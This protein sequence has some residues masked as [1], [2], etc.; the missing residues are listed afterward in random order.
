MDR[1]KATVSNNCD[2][3]PSD[4]EAILESLAALRAC[5]AEMERVLVTRGIAACMRLN[6]K[7][8]ER[9]AALEAALR[10]IQEQRGC[11][12]DDGQCP[13]YARCTYCIAAAALTPQPATVAP[14]EC[15]CAGDPDLDALYREGETVAKSATFQPLEDRVAEWVRTR[16]G[17]DHMNSRERSMRLLEEA[18]ELAQAEGISWGLAAKQVAHVYDREPG[19]PSQEA[20]GVAICLLG[21]CAS[22]SHTFEDLATKE[23]ARIEAKPLDQIRGSLARKADA[24]LVT[25]PTPGP[26]APRQ[27]PRYCEPCGRP[28]TKFDANGTALCDSCHADIERQR[29]T[30]AE[31]GGK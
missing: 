27:S 26:A 11:D 23:L 25:M 3:R 2:M 29:K 5:I 19:E 28:A 6:A 22:T 1:I 20:A 7:Q 16:I 10:E 14:S 13:A 8:A 21:W 30:L 24:D 4:E 31:K 17:A 15:E 18:V 9:I 12:T